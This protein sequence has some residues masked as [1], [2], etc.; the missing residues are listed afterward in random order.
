VTGVGTSKRVVVW[1]TAI[2]KLATPEIL[3]V[4]GH[5]M[6]HYVLHHIWLGIAL[7]CVGLLFSLW[8]VYHFLNWA[9]GRW[10]TRY[11]I[12]AIGDWSSAPLLLVAAAVLGFVG[13][14]IAN[15]ISRT[16]E[17]N[18]DIY[19]LEVIHGLVPDAPQVA[20]RSF[21]VLGELSLSDP[22]PGP[23][24]EFWLYDHPTIAER[25]EFAAEYDPWAHGLAP[26]YIK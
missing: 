1:D 24:V 10:G 23:L 16:M 26:R 2:Q 13:D 4:F 20:A 17:H 22:N 8:V 9:I 5:E 12:P 18:A 21:Q 25:V 7:S 3:F 6:G 19:G 11:A 15:S 14:P